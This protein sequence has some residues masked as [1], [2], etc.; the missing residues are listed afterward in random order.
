MTRFSPF[1]IASALALSA[2]C[3]GNS[4]TPGG[5]ANNASPGGASG[6]GG[7][8]SQ[9]AG[10]TPASGGISTAGGTGGAGGAV[11]SGGTNGAESAGGASGGGGNPSGG[12]DGS[13][14]SSGTSGANSGGAPNSGGT[15]GSGGAS[16]DAGASAGGMSGSSGAGGAS[17]NAGTGGSSGATGAVAQPESPCSM[18]GALACAGNHQRVTL[19]CSGGI[20]QVGEVC[21]QNYACDSTP[22]FNQGSC[23]PILAECAGHEP[24]Y[25]FCSST[26]TSQ[27]CGPDNVTLV[28]EV[29]TGSCHHNACDNRPNHCPIGSYRNCGTECR[30]PDSQCFPDVS[31]P[32]V[33][34]AP[35]TVPAA[36]QS[37]I[38][39]TPDYDDVC[40]P[41][42]CDP[43]LRFIYTP[44]TSN[45]PV[46]VRITVGGPWRLA[47][48]PGGGGCPAAS[49]V[50][51]LIWTPL[52]SNY[53]QI[54]TYDP[55]APEE[56]VYFQTAAA[57]EQLECP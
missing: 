33:V 12:T 30:E 43:R 38:I 57:G 32:C 20:W 48:I 49:A 4:E 15:N 31:W 25:T 50:T 11:D 22:G 19:V 35:I 14:A 9:S 29:C 36:G 18:P 1:A 47:A 55:S 34:M 39:R 16:G 21:A 24:G 28:P 56:N 27:R 3:G 17:G 42:S 23:R 37:R 6:S 8:N 26:T 7:T 40:E 44:F 45:D 54:F 46:H 5:N 41:S 53:I 13:G 51:C 52:L 2:A 10:G